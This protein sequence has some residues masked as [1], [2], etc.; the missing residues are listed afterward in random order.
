M[1]EWHD[2]LQEYYRYVY[3]FGINNWRIENKIQHDMNIFYDAFKK[4]EIYIMTIQKNFNPL[5]VDL[6]S[7]LNLE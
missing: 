6:S 4:A 3:L 1:Y 2:C 7:L 5:K